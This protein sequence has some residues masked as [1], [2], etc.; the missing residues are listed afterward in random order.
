MLRY[1]IVN[2]VSSWSGSNGALKI[3]KPAP[4][5]LL[6]RFHGQ[7]FDLAFARLLVDACEIHASQH[8]RIAIFHDWELMV[9]YEKDARVLLTDQARRLAPKVDVFAVFS[10]STMV[11]LGVTMANVMLDGR[12]KVVNDRFSFDTL[13][14]NTRMAL[15]KAAPGGQVAAGWKSAG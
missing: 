2:G 1:A 11:Q 10:K 6:S 15:P 14:E 9:N 7:T 12:I 13:L 8:E 4:Q 5:L 3:S